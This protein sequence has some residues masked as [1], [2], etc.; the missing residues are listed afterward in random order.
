M[1]P[2]VA[3]CTRDRRVDH[4]VSF[5]FTLE[6]QSYGLSCRDALSQDLLKRPPPEAPAEPSVLIHGDRQLGF[7]VLDEHVSGVHEESIEDDEAHL[8][9]SR[10]VGIWDESDYFGLLSN[11]SGYQVDEGRVQTIVR[12]LP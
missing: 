12:P 6:P 2:L 8:P 10:T 7:T 9:L 1:S 11:A 3:A 5:A 4:H